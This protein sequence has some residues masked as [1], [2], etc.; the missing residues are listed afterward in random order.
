MNEYRFKTSINCGACVSKVTTL[1]NDFEGIDKWEV[2]T[3][4]PLKILTVYADN[5][6]TDYLIKML[7]RIG[8]EAVIC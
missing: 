2:D 3:T 8:F 6:D 7:K 1:L 5:L 4:D